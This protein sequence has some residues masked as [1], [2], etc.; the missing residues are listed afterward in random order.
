MQRAS[1]EDHVLSLEN[2]GEFANEKKGNVLLVDLRPPAKAEEN[3]SYPTVNIPLPD[4]LDAANLELLRSKET[5]AL[6]GASNAQTASA[7]LLLT[8]LGFANVKTVDMRPSSGLNGPPETARYDFAAVFKN[9][10]Q[11]HATEL[12]AGKP[13]PE[14]KRVITPKPKPKKKAVAEEEGC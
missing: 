7:W 8:Q 3:P 10:Q 13:K 9:A 2:F 6:Q 11:R 14:A 1:T 5:V 4:L 12:E